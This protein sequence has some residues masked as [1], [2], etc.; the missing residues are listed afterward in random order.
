MDMGDE[1]NTQLA[2]RNINE[3]LRA[4]CVF[5]SSP[6]SSGHIPFEGKN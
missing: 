5:D 4:N 3:C 2:L 1:S 6:I